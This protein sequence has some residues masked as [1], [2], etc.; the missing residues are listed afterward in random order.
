MESVIIRWFVL[1][2][3]RL[4]NRFIKKRSLNENK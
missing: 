1:I 3:S 2:R 4:D